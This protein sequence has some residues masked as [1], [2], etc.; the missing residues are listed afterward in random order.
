MDEIKKELNKKNLMDEIKYGWYSQQA[1]NY[2][3]TLY[4]YMDQKNEEVSCTT[5]TSM[6]ENPY[7][8]PNNWFYEDSKYL[9]EI[10]KFIRKVD[11][12]GSISNHFIN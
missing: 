10:T 5:I 9:G 4:V 1:F 6:K 2:T 7:N 11:Y 12:S 8:R 3:K